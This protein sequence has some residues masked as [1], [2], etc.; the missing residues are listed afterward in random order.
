[1]L[2]VVVVWPNGLNKLLPGCGC[3]W[4]NKP[5]VVV[6]KPPGAAAA[7]AAGATFGKMSVKHY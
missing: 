5:P 1:M 3:V 2:G 6:P 4:L 7:A